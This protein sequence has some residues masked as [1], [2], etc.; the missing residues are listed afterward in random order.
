MNPALLELL[1]QCRGTC[2]FSFIDEPF[3]DVNQKG[4]GNNTPLHVVSHWG[5]LDGVKMLVEAGAEINALDTDFR[6]PLYCAVMSRNV[7]VVKYLLEQ[8][9][10]PNIVGDDGK[11]AL[12]FSRNLSGIPK[13]IVS[14]LESVTNSE[15]PAT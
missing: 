10:D 1:E 8:G 13:E 2:D 9:C 5:E 4:I 7:L 11:S 15:P 14:L 6:T 3:S 12:R